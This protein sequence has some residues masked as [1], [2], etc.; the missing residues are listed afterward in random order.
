MSIADKMLHDPVFRLAMASVARVAWFEGAG[1]TQR[2]VPARI[3]IPARDGAEF[4]SPAS[5]PGV[6]GA[7]IEV[8]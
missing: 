2:N 3:E 5:I 7:H 1:I 6:E 8:R 4:H